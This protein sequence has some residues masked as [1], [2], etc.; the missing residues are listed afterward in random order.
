MHILRYSSE[1]HAEACSISTKREEE[2]PGQ[3]SKEPFRPTNPPTGPDRPGRR[4]CLRIGTFRQQSRPRMAKPAW[5]DR[6]LPLI[7]QYDF[8]AEQVKRYAI[9]FCGTG[10]RRAPPFAA[11]RRGEMAPSASASSVFSWLMRLETN[12]VTFL[13]KG[14]LRRIPRTPAPGESLAPRRNDAPHS[15]PHCARRPGSANAK[16][17]PNS[18]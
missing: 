12:G 10:D 2:G 3:A 6:L 18:I 4:K 11:K 7:R 5:R 13:A 14:E 9:H 16:Q 8:D 17:A 1:P 15:G